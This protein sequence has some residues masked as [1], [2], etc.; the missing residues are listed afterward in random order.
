MILASCAMQKPFS[1]PKSQKCYPML[2]YGISVA[3]LTVLFNILYA[4]SMFCCKESVRDTTLFFKWP[5]D[6]GEVSVNITETEQWRT[7]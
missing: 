2:S 7:V 3:V 5:T 1:T 6:F 4:W